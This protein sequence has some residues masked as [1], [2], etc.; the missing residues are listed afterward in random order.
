MVGR[1]VRTSASPS[2]PFF[3]LRAA[4]RIVLAIRHLSCLCAFP[5]P[6]HCPQGRH[7]ASPSSFCLAG[8]SSEQGSTLR[9]PFSIH[10]LAVAQHGCQ[11][12]Q[13]RRFAFIWPS[14][15]KRCELYPS[16]PRHPPQN[17][18]RAVGPFAHQSRR[19]APF[20]FAPASILLQGR[21]CQGRHQG[22]QKVAK[23]TQRTV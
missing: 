2:S 3:V 17:Q 9:P 22:R 1:A 18:E 11:R 8:S 4:I 6:L 10:R 5:F 23:A 13:R 15:R 21:Q 20:F 19:I 14:Y 12:P 16:D 7:S